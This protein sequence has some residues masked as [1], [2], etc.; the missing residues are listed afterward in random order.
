[1]QEK[2]WAKKKEKDDIFYWLPLKQHLLDTSNIMGQLWNHWLS[3]GQKELVISMLSNKNEDTGLNTVR[4]LGAIHDLGKSTPAF[5]TKKSYNNQSY[6]LDIE[7]QERLIMSGFTGLSEMNL[8]NSESS[9]HAIAGEALLFEYG[10]GDDIGSIIGGH[11]GKPVD[12]KLVIKNQT[13][14][15]I[16]NY[17]QSDFDESTK[18]K[19]R[20]VQKEIFEW[21]MEKS[22][23]KAIKEIPTI[24][25]PALVLLEGMIIMADWIASNEEYFPLFLLDDSEEDCNQKERLKYGWNKWYKSPVWEYDNYD[26]IEER[27]Q[28]RFGFMPREVQSKFSQI[29]SDSI[30]PGIFILEA[31]MGIGKTEAALLAVEQL[32]EKRKCSGMF[33][34]LPTQATSDGIFKRIEDWV[35]KLANDAIGSWKISI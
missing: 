33:F 32:S 14:E 5:Q 3:E 24:E 35:E 29:I 7:L 22:N 1:M 28:K 23:F 34:G 8:A 18:I 2:L 15:Y 4:F 17:F 12:S 21:A 19:W 13:R 30:K 27:Y 25:Q 31:P 16:S 26:S 6:E 9:P 10:V 20:S 11:H